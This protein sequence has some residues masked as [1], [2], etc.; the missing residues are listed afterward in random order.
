MALQRSGLPLLIISII[1]LLA[2]AGVVL[3]VVQPF[4]NRGAATTADR[5]AAGDSSTP[6]PGSARDTASAAETPEEPTPAPEP[7]PAGPEDIIPGS[8]R[9]V[10]TGD[11]LYSIAGEVWADPVIWPVLL[12]A[13]DDSIIDPDYLRP[14]FPLTVPDWPEVTVPLTDSRRDELS[15]AHVVAYEHYRSLGA[16]AVGLGQGRP[17]WWLQR[18]GRTRDSNARWVLYSGLRYNQDLLVDFADRIAEADL[19]E[20]RGYISRFGLPLDRR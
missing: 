17:Q 10:R 18:L 6:A 8:V 5:P 3:L 16:N 12:L 20:V 13:N 19:R 14:G 11:S 1:L 15:A 9:T 4:G 2:I 7:Q